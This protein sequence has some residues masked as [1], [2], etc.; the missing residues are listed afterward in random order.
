[1]VSKRNVDL[2]S[3]NCLN[4]AK[5]LHKFILLLPDI[6]SILF[7]DKKDQSWYLPEVYA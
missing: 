2:D 3:L 5:L 1:M 6:E 7:P 4:E